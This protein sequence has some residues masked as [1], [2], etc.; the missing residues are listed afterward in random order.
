[1][2]ENDCVFCKIASGEEE[3][4][5][6]YEEEGMMAFRSI[7]G[8]APIHALFVTRDHV[9]STEEIG[10]LSEGAAKRIFEAAPAVAEK[11]D[12]VGS[13]YAF[14]VNNGSDAGQEVFDLRAHVLGGRKMG[15]P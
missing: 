6:V 1:M 5:V 10:Q 14:G 11:V 15:M 9:S 4:E 3:L 7:G 8:E 13:S 12:V 2:S